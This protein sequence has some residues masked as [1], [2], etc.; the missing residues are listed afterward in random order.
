MG[1]MLL[2]G[3]ALSVGFAGFTGMGSSAAPTV[4]PAAFVQD[5]KAQERQRAIFINNQDAAGTA[6][7]E[8]NTQERL[9]VDHDAK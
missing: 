1:K 4:N 5:Q 2:G 9:F 3:F 7:E 8:S 6:E